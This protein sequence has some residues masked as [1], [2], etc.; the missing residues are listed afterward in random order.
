MNKRQILG[1][2]LQ[3]IGVMGLIGMVF[4]ISID[5]LQG[6]EIIGALTVEMLFIIIGRWI[7]NKAKIVN[8]TSNNK[9]TNKILLYAMIVIVIFVIITMLMAFLYVYGVFLPK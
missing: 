4:E 1:I 6:Y 2:L 8:E 3:I 9:K 7:Y 5:L